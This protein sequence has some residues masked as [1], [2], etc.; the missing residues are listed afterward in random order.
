MAQYLNNIQITK[1]YKITTLDIK[2]LYSN[3]PIQNIINTVKFWLN[4]TNNEI[5][6]V[7]PTLDLIKVILNLNYFQYIFLSHTM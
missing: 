5:I 6:I 2:Y 7:K 3:L 1:Q 4:K